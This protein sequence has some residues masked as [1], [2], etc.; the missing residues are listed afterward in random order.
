MAQLHD[1]LNN[2]QLRDSI[3]QLRHIIFIQMAMAFEAE[4]LKDRLF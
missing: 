2:Q 3:A 4:E 1:D